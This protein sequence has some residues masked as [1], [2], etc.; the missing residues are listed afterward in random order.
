MIE[1]DQIE[2]PRGYRLVLS[3]NCS[4]SWREL[5]IFYLITCLL[6]LAIGLFFAFNGMWMVLP[7]SGLEMLALGTGLYIVSRNAHRRE[8]ISLDEHH[9]RVE[10]GI[11]KVDHRWKFQTHWTRLKVA[12][13]DGRRSGKELSL[14]SHGEYVV[15]GDFLSKNEK[16]DL[17][18]R[19]KD[20]II[21][22]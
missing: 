22:L 21:R 2:S 18:F 1:Y 13:K 8:V 10:K 20:C 6:A 15:V 11:D 17:A 16:D 9:V 5:I 14:G 7:F 3:P 4:I 19:L 12:E